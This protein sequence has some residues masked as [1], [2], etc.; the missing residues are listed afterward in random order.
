[1]PA[2]TKDQYATLTC[3]V[4][5]HQKSIRGELSTPSEAFLAKTVGIGLDHQRL[6]DESLYE[7]GRG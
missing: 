1:V 4:R 3:Q 2:G 7:K 5:V 6:V